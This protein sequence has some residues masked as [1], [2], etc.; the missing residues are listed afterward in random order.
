MYELT[1]VLD[2]VSD[3]RAYRRLEN[4]LLEYMPELYVP[5]I[6][7]MH[8]GKAILI[9]GIP[10]PQ[11]KTTLVKL[12]KDTGYIGTVIDICENPG[13]Q[14]ITLK[15]RLTRED[16]NKYREES[17]RILNQMPDI[18]KAKHLV[19]EYKYPVRDLGNL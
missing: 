16:M 12:I 17:K 4:Y 3:L 8:N 7:S 1:S 6:E 11:G 5:I 14:V 15:N 19:R 9:D 10:G 13:Y 18:K 2:Y